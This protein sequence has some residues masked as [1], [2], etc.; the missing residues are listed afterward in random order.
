MRLASKTLLA[1][2]L[3]FF[4]GLVSA[5]LIFTVR[6]SAAPSALNADIGILVLAH[7]AGPEWNQAVKDAVAGVNGGYKKVIVFGM[8]DA[9]SIQRGVD[10]LEKAGVK[11]IV[12]VPLFL[13]S[14][15]EMY[16]NLEYVLGIREE[17]DVLFWMLMTGG[18]EEGHAEHQMSVTKQVKFSVPH[19]VVPAIDYE[20]LVQAILVERAAEALRGKN[21]ASVFLLAHGPISA[22]D[23]NLW[24]LDLNR[25]TAVLSDRFPGA[26]FSAHTFRDDAPSFIKEPAVRKIQDAIKKE[27]ESGR[28]VVVIPYL[29]APGGREDEIGRITENCGCTVYLKTLLPHENFS[30]WIEREMWVGRKIQNSQEKLDIR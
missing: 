28:E 4:L 7:G 20:P 8:G 1:V 5:P 25:Y 6:A 3:L 24:L 30:L 18:E 23:N 22:E 29:L 2:A 11:A 10:K 14:H 13:S 27:K 12:V 19:A 16:R 21:D 15:S 26:K 17:P 9:S